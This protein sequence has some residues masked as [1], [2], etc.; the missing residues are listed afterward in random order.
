[1]K[2]RE[3][4]LEELEK[5]NILS[6]D[7][8]ESNNGLEDDERIII[9]VDD[10]DYDGIIDKFCEVVFKNSVLGDDDIEDESDQK[11]IVES[12]TDCVTDLSK[13]LKKL[14]KPY[15]IIQEFYHIDPSYRDTYYA[16]FSNQHFHVKR[17][18]RRLS[19]FTGDLSEEEFF[20]ADEKEEEL[21]AE[22][23]MGACVINPLTTGGIGRTLIDP[24]YIIDK[25]LLPVYVR[26]SS[27]SLNVYGKKFKV[28]AFPY[29]MQDEETMRCAEVSLLNLLEYYANSYHDYRSVVPSEILEYEQK[30][31][32]ER[33]L[34]SRG[35]SYPILTKVLS[36]FGFSPRLYNLSSI[37][38]Y[39]LS[40]ITQEDEL[41]RCLHYYI[42]SGIPVALNLLPMERNGAGHS[43]VCIGHGNADKELIKK[44]KRNKWISWENREH[45][46]PLINSAD[47]YKDYVVVDDNQP[48]YQVEPFQRL[49]LYPDMRVENI[50]VPLYK[51]M[52]LDAFDA[53]AIVRS[54]L[55]N[56]QFGIDVWSNNFL[57][58]REDVIMRLFMA[59]SRS[60]KN[61]RSTK[62]KNEYAKEAYAMVPMP[63][64]VWVCELYRENDYEDL[65]AF[66]EIIIDATSALG[67][68]HNVRS[69][70]LMHYPKVIGIR[71]PEQT[72]S[73]F[74]KMIELDEDELFEGYRKNLNEVS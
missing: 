56:E 28:Q 36:E 60:L 37:D 50:A 17:Y 62:I 67:R 68:G 39:S 1:M 34:P 18:S 38:K 66:G 57:E 23:F 11:L 35:I 9:F 59:S 65:M 16:Y 40:Q 4:K 70:I 33:V 47:F 2:G 29:R 24:K 69:L 55:H 20:G 54:V 49:S 22:R 15:T 64:F 12:M 32:H 27:F 48:V 74:E 53:A 5:N 14:P 46:H 10:N 72:S 6:G 43:M 31:S 26:L 58:D 44:A 8:I 21:I 30:H 71:F 73:W 25:A 45:G 19:F 13:L 51:R 61:Y 41:K 42:E 3:I 52:F 7:K 63:R